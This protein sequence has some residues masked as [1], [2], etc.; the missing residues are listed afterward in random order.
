MIS[1]LKANL[2]RYRLTPRS[3]ISGRVQSLINA[4]LPAIGDVVAETSFRARMQISPSDLVQRTI[5]LAG[6]FEPQTVALA[7]SLLKPGDQFLDAGAHV[8]LFT[9][10]AGATGAHVL[11]I[12]AD[13]KTFARLCKNISLNDLKNVTPL[14]SALWSDSGILRMTR[15]EK[16]NTGM[17]RVAST[18][19]SNDG[20]VSPSIT[21]DRVVQ[22][23]EITAIK[24]LK[25]DIEGAEL[26]VLQSYFNCNAVKPENIIFE[27]WPEYFPDSIDVV[28]L[29][30]NSG[31]EIRDILGNQL[32]PEIAP[33]E[34]NLW[35]RLQF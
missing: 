22:D 26:P 29:L 15:P 12:E 10:A 18:S 24:L 25:M 23:L 13:P 20:F 28:S 6:A 14:C 31:Y 32:T 21:L 5:L 2:A 17:N 8:G 34:H 33:P 11:C 19:E 4:V 9:L 30:Q 27:Y 16:L 3:G 7:M 35:A 1:H